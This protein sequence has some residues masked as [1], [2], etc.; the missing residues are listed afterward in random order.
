V[1]WNVVHRSMITFPQNG[2]LFAARQGYGRLTRPTLADRP[3]S[4][5]SFAPA[6][7]GAKKRGRSCWNQ[8]RTVQSCAGPIS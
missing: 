1:A 6:R 7:S 4:A 2:Q 3:R 5:C 8:A